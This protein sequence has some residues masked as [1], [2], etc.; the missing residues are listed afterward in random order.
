MDTTVERVDQRMKRGNILVLFPLFFYILAVGLPILFSLLKLLDDIIMLFPLQLNNV[1]FLRAFYFS[2]LESAL[3]T[4]LTITV[5]SI[6]AY[7]LSSLRI[8]GKGV[9]KIVF[10]LPFVL[11]IIPLIIGIHLLFGSDGIITT[12]IRNILG[13]SI[14]LGRGLSGVVLVN[15][16]YGLP[17]AILYTFSVWRTSRETEEVSLIY[18]IRGVKKFFKITLPQILPGILSAALLIFLFS[19]LAFEA[20]LMLGGGKVLTIEMLIY[21]CYHTLFSPEKGFTL[22]IY[23]FGISV[24]IVITYIKV[25]MKY[26]EERK[27]IFGEVARIEREPT[28]VE[29]LIFY[30]ITAIVIFLIF[31][32]MIVVAFFALYDPI[33]KKLTFKAFDK[34]LNPEV[35]IVLGASLYKII[36]NT[37]YYAL[38]TMIITILL[39]S[40]VVLSKNERLMELV[41]LFSLGISPVTLG[42]SYLTTFGIT[43]L[44]YYNSWIF[45]IL[46]HTVI[47]LPMAIRVLRSGFSK[48][49]KDLIEIAHIYNAR[50]SFFFYRIFIP[51]LGPSFIV[52]TAFAF[53][54]SIGEY[55]A[56]INVYQGQYMTLPIAIYLYFRLR[57]IQLACALSLIYILIAFVIFIIIY[58]FEEDH[59]SLLLW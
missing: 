28:L 11:P 13:I 45:I 55:G 57:R 56:T 46:A 1:L 19:F 4:A 17:L 33:T 41:F 50:N 39:A 44:Y 32:P 29:Q 54:A 34:I 38:A 51:L 36:F 7:F 9:Y 52:A 3:S 21:M 48:I 40:A 37:I 6:I 30:I 53:A 20:P 8:K 59:I 43:D 15:F 49:D 23:Q 58:R 5:G 42:I 10:T 16:I 24:I 25:I 18:G 27:T 47:A 14:V 26:E 31:A 22:A 12:Y 35:E 2:F